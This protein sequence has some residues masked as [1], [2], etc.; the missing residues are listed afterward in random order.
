VSEPE[1][2]RTAMLD[3]HPL[4]WLAEVNGFLVV[5]ALVLEQ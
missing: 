3:Q 4:A 2:T 5:E 1:L